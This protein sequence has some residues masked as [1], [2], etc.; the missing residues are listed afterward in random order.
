M[1]QLLDKA[2]AEITKLPPE[3]QEAFLNWMLAELE[4]E[5]RWQKSFA[6]SADLLEQLADEA[7]AEHRA[8]KTEP[9]DPDT[10]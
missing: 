10:L 4:D 6:Q 1:T 7:L 2:I 5:R 3:E 9:L 8:G